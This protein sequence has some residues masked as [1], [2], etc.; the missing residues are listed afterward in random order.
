MRLPCGQGLFEATG[1]AHLRGPDRGVPPEVA[2]AV[3]PDHARVVRLHGHRESL[4]ELPAC[5][6]VGQ[7]ETA[8]PVPAARTKLGEDADEVAGGLAEEAIG[9]KREGD[10]DEIDVLLDLIVLPILVL[11]CLVA[12]GEEVIRAF[13]GVV[14]VLDVDA[15]SLI[16]CQGGPR[17]PTSVP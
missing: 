4:G 1:A 14:Q 13:G 3:R 7:R 5:T 15:L 8:L 9:R 10:D 17:G 11:L 2:Q 6:G 16:A 12:L